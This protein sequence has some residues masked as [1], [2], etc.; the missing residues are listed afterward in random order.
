MFDAKYVA[1]A[2]SVCSQLNWVCS[3]LVC[4]LFPSMAESLG[5]YSFLPFAVILAASFVFALT[6]MPETR[7]TT[8]EQLLLRNSSIVYQPNKEA[9]VLDKDIYREWRQGFVK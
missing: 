6:V 8:P 3:F 7:G 4:L 5:A 1:V 2:M 9:R